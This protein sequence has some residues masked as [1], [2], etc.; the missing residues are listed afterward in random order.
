MAQTAALLFALVSAGVG[1]FQVALTLGA[2]FGEFT[3]GGRWRGSL[4]PRVRLIPI[5]SILLL[6]TFSAVILARAGLGPPV[7]QEYSGQLAWVVVGYC[8]LGCVFR[9]IP[10]AVPL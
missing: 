3:L 1:A 4:P 5:V 10:D 8:V 6:G 7:I 2:P 9:A